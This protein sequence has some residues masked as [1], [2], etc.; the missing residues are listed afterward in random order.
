[1]N[2][3]QRMVLFGVFLLFAAVSMSIPRAGD[4]KDPTFLYLG[5]VAKGFS[6]RVPINVLRGA[7]AEILS[8]RRGT[9]LFR[10]TPNTDPIRIR[11]ALSLLESVYPDAEAVLDMARFKGSAVVEEFFGRTREIL[12]SRNEAVGAMGHAV[13][14]SEASGTS[15]E[16]LEIDALI[17]Q[18]AARAPQAADLAAADDPCEPNDTFGTATRIP[19]GF[20]P[21]L[22]SL[23]DDWYK[24]DLGASRD[25]SINLGD[26]SEYIVDLEIYDSMGRLLN[27]SAY[28]GHQG[29]I[30]KLAKLP[31]GY[32]YFKVFNP[33]GIPISYSL[34]I[35]K[36][37][38]FGTISG[39]ITSEAT[40]AGIEGAYVEAFWPYESDD[41]HDGWETANYTYSGDTG[42]YTLAVE[43]GEYQLYFDGKTQGDFTWEYYN[44]T[45]S[46]AAWA[47]VVVVK[48][49]DAPRK[50]A[51]LAPAG[52]IAGRVT[53]A[54]T[55]AGI[56]G[57]HVRAAALDWRTWTDEYYGT[58][59]SQGYYVIPAV[60]AG[61][62][63][64]IAE[65]VVETDNYLNQ[66]YDHRPDYATAD[67]IIVSAGVTT[68]NVDFSL[69]PGGIISGR[70]T[71]GLLGTGI[72]NVS[73]GIPGLD[74]SDRGATHAWTHTDGNGDYSVRSLPTGSYE[75]D[76]YPLPPYLEEHYNDKPPGEAATPVPVTAGQETPGIDAR[77]EEGG[78]I[79]G[80]VTNSLGNNLEG[81]SVSARGGP[82]DWDSSPRTSTYTVSGDGATNYR[83]SGLRPGDYKVWFSG[84]GT[85]ASWEWYPNKDDEGEAVPV[86]VAAYETVSGIDAQLVGGGALKVSVK[87]ALGAA[88][89]GV[90]V[91]AVN[92]DPRRRTGTEVT[93]INGTAIIL[94][95]PGQFRVR[96][97]STGGQEYRSEYYND[98]PDPEAADLVTISEGSEIA[99]EA[100]LAPEAPVVVVAPGTGDSWY[101]GTT[102]EIRW[103]GD[104][105]RS[106]N[107]KI[108][109]YKGVTF[110]KAL[111]AQT[112]NDNS[113][114][115]AIPS[116]TAAAN[117]YIIKIITLANRASS[118]GG[119]FSIVK[120]RITIQAPI[121]SS[122][123]T[124]GT[125]HDIAWTTTGP[126]AATV[127]ILLLKDGM[128]VRTIAESTPNS[129]NFAW[130]IPA[131]GLA[132]G[133]T[134]K[135][136]IQTVDRAVTKTSPAFT[137]R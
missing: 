126:M 74:I 94:L 30:I 96:F 84:Y 83:L 49:S 55:G 51:S 116:S 128:L 132:R 91:S 38:L 39:R 70:V 79:T 59:D 113:F 12:A 117:N 54:S 85:G 118:L 93:D 19:P 62:A 95:E 73:I 42:H 110:V 98:K 25:L 31:P 121:G 103:I 82:A 22:R 57:I 65:N 6:E 40:G 34:S 68:A 28:G 81:I 67:G 124:R 4:A 1:M 90:M 119:Y 108:Q 5:T 24:V 133:T 33:E 89:P 52:R 135:I 9:I 15:G 109:L 27:T 71:D 53:S 61:N 100:I 66:W 37:S 32:Y 131:T 35:E 47:E 20:H 88:L 50:N 16:M 18:R 123:W 29:R 114:L 63:K 64:V 104:A 97:S 120:P 26:G 45:H 101:T 69:S 8:A 129:G 92:I 56:G 43:P 78:T 14:L 36:G 76:F 11:G 72:E 3:S 111:A 10:L 41:Y 80:R 87:S 127:R 125:T 75:V 60:P 2:K 130:T 105:S 86:T 99:I 102:G 112:P 106:P 48:S 122:I 77:L 46:E 134:Y 21:G 44:N 137:I 17:R 7:G 115:W 23:N 136:K 13:D 58:T 107:V